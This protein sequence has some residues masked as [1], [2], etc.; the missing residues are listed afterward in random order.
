MP[1]GKSRV[2]LTRRP[3]NLHVRSISQINVTQGQ[4]L[5]PIF[6]R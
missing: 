6:L 4:S 5:D 3:K 1:G 2:C